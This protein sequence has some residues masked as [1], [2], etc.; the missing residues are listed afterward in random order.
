[1]DVKWGKFK[2]Y[3]LKIDRKET[4]LTETRLILGQWG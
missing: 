3:Y 2:N 1:M 4:G